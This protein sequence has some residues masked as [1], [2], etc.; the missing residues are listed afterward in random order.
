[1]GGP[2]GGGPPGGGPPKPP[3]GLIDAIRARIANLT[4]VNTAAAIAALAFFTTFL[5]ALLGGGPLSAQTNPGAF[6]QAF[7]A[8]AGLASF[9]QA[10]TPASGG[11][12][13]PPLPLNPLNIQGIPNWHAPGY[14]WRARMP[15]DTELMTATGFVTMTDVPGTFV[16]SDGLSGAL[17][18]CSDLV[19]YDDDGFVQTL[20]DFDIEESADCEVGPA[21]VHVEWVEIEADTSHRSVFVYWGQNLNQTPS[22]EDVPGTWSNGYNLVWHGDDFIEA[23]TRDTIALTLAPPD[24]S[25][26]QPAI[27]S[28]PLGNGFS[29]DGVNDIHVVTLPNGDPAYDLVQGQDTSMSFFFRDRDEGNAAVAVRQDNSGNQLHNFEVLASNTNLRLRITLDSALRN[30]ENPAGDSDPYNTWRYGAYTYDHVNIVRYARDGVDNVTS[31]E[32]DLQDADQVTVGKWT[33]GGWQ[34]FIEFAGD[35]TEAR[36]SWVA[37]LLEWIEWERHNLAQ[38]AGIYDQETTIPERV[39]AHVVMWGDSLSNAWKS[40]ACGYDWPAPM[41]CQAFGNGGFRARI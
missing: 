41:T 39:E 15:A 31:A 20:L 27:I 10:M 38:Q 14:N 19:F 3:P 26:D 37:R 32:T 36:Y 1:M 29:Y 35:I 23:I 6:P 7:D 22:A 40:R 21:V 33:M 34:T 18:D 16:F 5:L 9:D 8:S 25:H 12:A 2:P 11:A 17:A 13:D 30:F 4:G 24:G 28:S